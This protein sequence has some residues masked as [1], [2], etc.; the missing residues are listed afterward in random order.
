M[1]DEHRVTGVDFYDTIRDLGILK[2]IY[3]M[4]E[5]GLFDIY[6]Y[7][8]GAVISISKKKIGKKIFERCIDIYHLGAR[9][10]LF[11]TRGVQRIH[12][13]L[14]TTYFSWFLL[15]LLILLYIFRSWVK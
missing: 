1:A 8:A 6:H 14:F 7:G 9:L 11:L 15:G 2:G 5:Q 13:G 12:T 10:I 3:K 4:A